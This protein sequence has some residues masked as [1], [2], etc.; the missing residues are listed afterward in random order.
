MVQPSASEG[1]QCNPLH[2]NR[3]AA[4]GLMSEDR[5]NVSWSTGRIPQSCMSRS[6][7]WQEPASYFSTHPPACPLSLIALFLYLSLSPL[8]QA[9]SAPLSFTGRLFLSINLSLILPA[10]L[11]YFLLSSHSCSLCLIFSLSPCLSIHIH[12]S[13]TYI[14]YPIIF[15]HYTYPSLI[16]FS[17]SFSQFNFNSIFRALLAWETC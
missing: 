11:S 9:L 13:S 8:T 1:C 5:R 15:M 6:Q 10:S 14:R 3:A 2:P 7:C 16:S 4:S 17:F 12:I